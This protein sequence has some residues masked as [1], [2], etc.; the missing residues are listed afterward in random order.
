MD[1][2]YRPLATLISAAREEIGRPILVGL[3]GAQ[4]SGKTTAAAA[5]QILLGH[6]G[7][8][9]AIVSIDDLYLTRRERLALAASVHPL[10]ATRGPPGTHEVAM[11]DALVA[12]LL[13]GAPC[14][15]PRFDKSADDRAPPDQWQTF[16]GGAD[17]VLLEGWFVGAR[18]QEG[19]ALIPP[20]NRLEA[21]EDAEAT[22]RTYVN[23]AL[24]FYQP[25]F[26]SLDMLIQLRAPDFESIVRWRREQE[27]K[28]RIQSTARGAHLM[29]DAEIQRF[30]DHYERLTRHILSEMPSR[31]DVVIALGPAREL[32][33][34][35]ENTR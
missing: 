22:W 11:L 12:R 14:S 28:L 33:D 9:V 20:I 32:V 17:V 34:W 35:T 18:P 13:G 16:D 10:L 19:A 6:A 7:L 31:A 8:K 5:L 25:L 24:E 21:D 4:G 1:R 30:V 29:S 15:W 27:A 23:A 2:I 26:H 3:C